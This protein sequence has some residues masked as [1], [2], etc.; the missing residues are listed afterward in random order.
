V[1]NVYLK[2]FKCCLNLGRYHSPVLFN[3]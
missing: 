2:T 3:K 1:S